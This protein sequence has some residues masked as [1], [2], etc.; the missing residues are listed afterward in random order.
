[1]ATRTK[2]TNVFSS[3]PKRN[4]NGGEYPL[5]KEKAVAKGHCNNNKQV[6]YN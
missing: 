1:M 4:K 3:P 2:M 6:S 5:T